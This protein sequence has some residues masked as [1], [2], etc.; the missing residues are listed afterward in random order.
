MKS[1]KFKNE[2]SATCCF[3]TFNMGETKQ[4]HTALS[5]SDETDKAEQVKVEIYSNAVNFKQ[6]PSS[7][8]F[9]ITT[10][11][12]TYHNNIRMN[13]SQWGETEKGGGAFLT[14]EL[15]NPIK[16]HKDSEDRCTTS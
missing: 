6:H 1:F 7:T 13:I 10:L 14:E 12:I 8:V 15:F 9:H 16:L 4:H 3:Y 2:P 5:Y 11:G